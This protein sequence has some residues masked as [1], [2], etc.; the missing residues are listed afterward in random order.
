M[1]GQAR[2]VLP[3]PLSVECCLRIA[4]WVQQCSN[5]HKACRR[6]VVPPSLPTRVL[7]VGS[8]IDGIDS[9]IRLIETNGHAAEYIALSHCWGQRQLIV[10]SSKNYE[11]RQKQIHYG[12]L[13]KTFRDAVEVCRKLSIPYLWIDSLCIV[14][15]D[16]ADW[17]RE[18][19]KMG[20]I[21]ENAYVVIAAD[22]AT[23]G[24]KGCLTLRP[25]SVEI[26]CGPAFGGDAPASI[27]AR[28][29]F[30]HVDLTVAVA[31][32]DSRNPL[33]TRAWALQEWLLPVRVLHFTEQEIIWDCKTELDCECS[34]A[35][36]YQKKLRNAAE[37]NLRQS[38]TRCLEVRSTL[39][40][41][42]LSEL[43]RLWL[44]I[45]EEYSMRE[46]TV[47]TDQ[48]P[49][50]SGLAHRF[51][52]ADSRL[53]RYVA[54]LWTCDFI[55]QLLWARYPGDDPLCPR[56]SEFVAPTWSWASI[57][58]PVTWYEEDNRKYLSPVT[59]KA[60]AVASLEDVQCQPSG[61]DPFGRLSSGYVLLAAPAIY[62]SLP[63]A[64]DL[65]YGQCMLRFQ[66]HEEMF[67][68]DVD[69]SAELAEELPVVCIKI[70]E[71]CDA[72]SEC[73]EG[74]KSIIL[75][76]STTAPGF[77][78]RIGMDD[79]YFSSEWFEGASV[80]TFKII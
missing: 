54:G 11:D 33:D 52:D 2:D 27:F 15:D 38:L 28:P 18:S 10:T 58:E 8:D 51:N 9:G 71:V 30:S 50:I 6:E 67:T 29:S 4:Q 79:G 48:L 64:Q 24:D 16:K 26:P 77:Y 73:M 21:Y 42:D 59:R 46:L 75:K 34:R 22:S 62:A 56:P 65:T 39:A 63:T 17:E 45:I 68:I 7:D 3:E 32:R 35:R 25:P 13:S 1:F 36:T 23:D 57:S 49:A 40:Y 72:E 74:C 19:S 12:Q 70:A 37:P 47:L 78:E 20:A 5:S 43:I 14:Q 60:V 80:Q 61:L 55:L 66:E 41:G 69:I 44:F 53:G 31:D 76:H